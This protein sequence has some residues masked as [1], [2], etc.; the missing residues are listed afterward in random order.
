MGV[1]IDFIRV[2]MRISHSNGELRSGCKYQTT[3]QG[4]GG[5]I[6]GYGRGFAERSPISASVI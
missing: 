1:W 4:R 6:S 2:H 5:I 3:P